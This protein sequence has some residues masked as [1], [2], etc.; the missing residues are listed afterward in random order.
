MSRIP[1]HY[2]L[3]FDISER[4]SPHHTL[5]GLSYLDLMRIYNN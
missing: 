3:I 4:R 2:L 5:F 1:V